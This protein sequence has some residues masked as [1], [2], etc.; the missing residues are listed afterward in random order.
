MSKLFVVLFVL[1]V[2]DTAFSRELFYLT[3]RININTA[4]KEELQMLPLIGSKKAKKIISYRNKH[5]GFKNQKELLRIDGIGKGIFNSIKQYVTL[6]DT[7]N[8]R[9]LKADR[10]LIT[11]LYIDS[12]KGPVKALEDEKYFFLLLDKIKGA[13][14]HITVCVY[15]FKTTSFPENFANMIMKELINASRRGV[16][17]EVV[18][19]RNDRSG[20]NLNRINL[21]TAKKM[22]KGGI[23]VR[24][25]NR[26]VNTHSKLV[27]IDS[28]YI[29]IGSHNLTHTALSRSNETSLMIESDELARY[30]LDYVKRIK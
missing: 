23:K 21:E 18:L 10:S 17:V 12:F 15:L 5:S 2:F 30:F 16:D 20:D 22:R 14:E 29:F 19:E 26:S 8:L 6:K 1:F 25:D 28:K 7:S 27:I 3:G 4:T 24:F 13:K 9:Y 11:T